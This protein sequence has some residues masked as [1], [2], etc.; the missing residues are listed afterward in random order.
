MAWGVGS[1]EGALVEH[2]S[3]THATT[4]VRKLIVERVVVDLAL[5]FHQIPNAFP[6]KSMYAI[7]GSIGSRVALRLI[8]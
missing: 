4:T 7:L 8:F 1:I 2:P 5:T 6:F 3:Q